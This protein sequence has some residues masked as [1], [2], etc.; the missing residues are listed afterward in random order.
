MRAFAIAT[1][2]TTLAF[3][4]PAGAATITSYKVSGWSMGAY[5]NDTTG[6]F[7]HCAASAQYRNGLLLLFSVSESF[8]WSIGFSSN[9]WNLTQGRD[10]EVDFR[11]DGGRLNTVRGTAVN[12]RL[13]RAPLPD[14]VDLFNQFR[15]GLRLVVSLNDNAPVTF[16]L[17]DTNA[18]LSEILRCAQKYKGYADRNDNR[19][20]ATERDDRPRP[21]ER[22]DDRNRPTERD[23]GSRSN[24]RPPEQTR[25]HEENQRPQVQNERNG[26]TGSSGSNNRLTRMPERNEER[27][28]EREQAPV[29]PLSIGPTPDSRMEAS[30]IAAD[31]LRRANF[32]FEFQ[33]PEQLTAELRDRQDVVWRSEEFL[34]TLRILPAAN[35]QTID[36]IRSDVVAADTASCKGKLD[37]GA[38]P[39][40][41]DSKSVTMFTVCKG[42]PVRSTYY[43][44]LPRRKGGI[45]LLGILGSGEAAAR[46]QSVASAYR[47]VALEV[48]EK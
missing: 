16:N 3:A 7:S 48:L 33:K 21:Q 15:V 42:E 25:Q 1:V 24:N 26:G 4:A 23:T 31:I 35:A 36:K 30:Q 14:S 6:R 28:P 44:L 45:Y 11:V 9:D 8:Q 2:A 20:R 39:A 43:I 5:T 19:P 22:S 17:T 27:R 41:A 47:T 29:N 38:L 32:T 34:G 12:T 46:V 10:I 40:M 18:M 37:T 13:L